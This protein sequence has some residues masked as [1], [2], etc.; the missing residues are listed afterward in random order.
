[1]LHRTRSHRS[2]RWAY[3]SLIPVVLLAMVLMACMPAPVSPAEEQAAKAL[4]FAGEPLPDNPVF[5]AGLEKVMGK[6]KSNPEYCH[7]L[8]LRGARY[9]KEIAEM[10]SSQG[11]H[12][13]FFYLAVAES[14]L[15][16]EANSSMGACGVWQFLPAT[17][18]SYGMKVSDDLDE[19][20]DV[21]RSTLA[22][23]EYLNKYQ[24]EFGT[25]TAAALAFNR[26]PKVLRETEPGKDL[27]GYYKL[28]HD[29]GYLYTIIAI[30]QLFESPE[31]YGIETGP[32]FGLPLAKTEVSSTYGPRKS[33]FDG[34]IKNHNG[35]DFKAP[36]GTEVLA[37]SDGTVAKAETDAT[38][39]NGHLIELTHTSPL[40]SRYHHLDEVRVKP[41]QK[42]KKGEV[43]GTVGN[44]GLSTAPHLHLEIRE[45]DVPV[46]PSLYI[47][48]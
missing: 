14:A 43:I 21:A 1:M 48:Y 4:T 22:A 33:P 10:L 9:Q 11:V 31:T 15:D 17:A 42:V 5:E 47:R 13:D 45:K 2:S 7:K 40:S 38:S 27:Q 18:E 8:S 26:G 36:L 19:R 23:G 35:V 6:L 24:S 12:P 46:D 30:K 32:E 3:T 37:I 28:D 20:K 29:R 39:K 25:W 16:P 41:G 44:T 34:K